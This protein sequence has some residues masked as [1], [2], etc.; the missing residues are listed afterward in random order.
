MTSYYQ[1]S[2]N[3]LPNSSSDPDLTER[4]DHW[5]PHLLKTHNRDNTLK[6]C[7]SPSPATS[8]RTL[9]PSFLGVN[10]SLGLQLCGKP[11]TAHAQLHQVYSALNLEHCLAGDVG[12][13]STFSSTHSHKPTVIWLSPF[14]P[15]PVLQVLIAAH[16][17]G[18]SGGA[19][20][21]SGDKFHVHEFAGDSRLQR[22]SDTVSLHCKSNMDEDCE[23]TCLSLAVNGAWTQTARCSMKWRMCRTWCA[24]F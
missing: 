24:W 20:A 19:L 5:L 4:N 15:R 1:Q 22:L 11:S 2:D 21:K 12:N 7:L 6:L 13:S 3:K 14:A 23:N 18:P 9:P 8:R 10:I 16:T 17:I